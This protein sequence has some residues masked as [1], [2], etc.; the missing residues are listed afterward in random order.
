[1]YQLQF[2]KKTTATAE[3]TGSNGCSRT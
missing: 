2:S 3:V 1:M